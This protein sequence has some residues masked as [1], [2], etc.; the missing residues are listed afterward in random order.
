MAADD[1]REHRRPLSC[2][3]AMS[4]QVA[5]IGGVRA[6]RPAAAPIVD[7]QLPLPRLVEEVWRVGTDQLGVM[8]SVHAR[9]GRVAVAT[10]ALHRADDAMDEETS[11]SPAIDARAD[12]NQGYERERDGQHRCSPLHGRLSAVGSHGSTVRS[13]LRTVGTASLRICDI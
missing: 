8:Q 9:E 6:I 1:A 13:G 3:C 4:I 12:R 7:G 11:E 5:V 2:L 10:A